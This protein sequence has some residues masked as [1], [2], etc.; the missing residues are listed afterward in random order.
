MDG[1]EWIHMYVFIQS[2]Q[3]CMQVDDIFN[4]IIIYRLDESHVSNAKNEMI[5]FQQQQQQRMM[6]KIEEIMIVCIKCIANKY[7]CRYSS[8]VHI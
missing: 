7:V 1:G 3:L 8:T 4:I 5:L 2:M 6:S